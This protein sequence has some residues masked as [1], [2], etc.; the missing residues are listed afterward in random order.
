MS[1]K[2]YNALYIEFCKFLDTVPHEMLIKK[3]AA[4]GA[5]CD[6]LKWITEWFADRKQ[7]V[8]I[9]GVVNSNWRS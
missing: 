1:D 3:V 9:T 4:H 6:V 8:S 7:R 5:V 2:V